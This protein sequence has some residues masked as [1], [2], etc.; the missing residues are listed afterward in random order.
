[1]VQAGFDLLV[2]A[3][4]NEDLIVRAEAARLLGEVGLPQAVG[5]L[6]EYVKRDRHYSKMTALRSLAQIGDRSVVDELAALV[7]DPNA[8]DDWYWHGRKTVRA[9]AA[10]ALLQLGSDAGVWYLDEL[11]EK[12]DDS[13]FGWFAAEIL[14]L[15]AEF[16]AVDRVQKYL[17][18]E[19]ICRRGS[20]GIRSS[21]PGL[22][23]LQAEALGVL[24]DEASRV[25]LQ[26]W[27]SF[28]SRYVRGQAA[29]S[30]VE[31][32]ASDTR[33]ALIGQL[34][35]GD[36]AAF[37]RMKACLAMWRATGQ[38]SWLDR[39]RATAA[40]AE[41]AFDQAA[42][43]EMLGQAR[44]A[45]DAACLM[46]QLSHADWY[47]RVCAVE[48]L[49][50]LGGAEAVAAARGLAADESLRVRMQVAAMVS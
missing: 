14:R 21:D 41:A 38:E 1:M 9:A 2:E 10:V 46:G 8:H 12:D 7:E 30:L 37:T 20:R 15:P 27:L 40:S 16:E 28:H 49:D 3:L 36:V 11:A 23:C 48:A 35:D 42:G 31:A 29:L 17:T 4:G 26:E 19:S 34:A 50:R 5:P 18:V 33:L 25:Q 47:V 44:R 22:I 6:L 39:L 13:L 24:G 32:G 45:S 43:V